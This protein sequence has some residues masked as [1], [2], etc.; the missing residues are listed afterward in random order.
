MLALQKTVLFADH[1]AGNA[2]AG[3][4]RRICLHVIF[5][6]MNDQRRSTIA[7]ERVAI[8]A[9]SQADIAVRQFSGR[10][11]VFLDREVQHVTG[12]VSFGILQTVFLSIGIKVRP[13]GLEV[14]TIALS[15]LVKVDRVCARGQVMQLE[16]K[17]HARALRASSAFRQ[18]NRAYA[19]ALSIFHLNHRLGRTGQRQE[20]DR[21]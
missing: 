11:A 1:A 14:W 2:I 8:G 5:L 6:G 17:T 21:E 7:E 19:L 9:I 4:S 15:V 13:G 3:V 10:L 18:R 20:N 16:L 12:V